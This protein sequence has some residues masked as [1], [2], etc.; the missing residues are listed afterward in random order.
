MISA[1][2]KKLNSYKREL[3]ITMPKED[4]EPIRERQARR[5]RKEAQ[6]PGFRKGKAPMGLIKKNYAGA[7]E[8]YTLDDAVDLG[9]RQAVDQHQLAI[10]GTPEAKKVDFDDEGNLLSVIEFDTY[11]EI[12]LKNYKGF[13]FTRDT[14]II[15]DKLVEETID[16]IRKEKAEIITVDDPVAEGHL[17][18]LDMQELD[19]EGK[20]IANKKYDNISVK[21]GEGRFDAELEK[22]LIGLKNDEEKIIEKVYP[23]D[24]PQKEFA[25]KKEMYK[26]KIKN[27]EEEK[28]P[29]LNDE[30]VKDF[31]EN[32]ETVEDLRRVTRENLEHQYR[33][34][35]E[36]RLTQDLTQ[37][38][39]EENPFDLPQ[40]LVDN[41]LDHVVEDVK[42]RDPKIKEEVIRQHYQ[43]EAI[44]NLK[45][46]YLQDA[47]AA[48]EHIEV[49]DED[50]QKF[51]D[52]LKDDKVREFYEANEQLLNNVKEDIRRRKVQDFLV[53]NSTIRENEINLD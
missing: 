39:I 29:E 4:L 1:E 33:V 11:P 23:D 7:I 9:L 36:D 15:T 10:I 31:S 45:W 26:V 28:L 16:R 34:E 40:A 51:L 13:E 44:F 35:A 5:V 6:F 37:K 42:R 53:A 50:V 24:F 48:K 12:E 43:T 49:S 22:Q 8:A 27:I 38:L 18:V 19:E 21:I 41:Y 46:Y 52:E 30:F 20:P 17:V 47:I 32:L 25:G 2:V 14:Y 3:T